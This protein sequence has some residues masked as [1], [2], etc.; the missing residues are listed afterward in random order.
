VVVVEAGR[1]SGS[2]NT[3]G[4]AT[5]LGRP[6]G[7]VPGPVTSPLSV[8][9]HALLRSGLA[10]CVTGVPDVVELVGG[11]DDLV[12]QAWQAEQ[13]VDVGRVQDALSTR[14]ERSTDE[15]AAASGL[16]LTTVRTLLAEMEADEL[17]ERRP[18]GWR[19]RPVP[20]RGYPDDVRATS[21]GPGAREATPVVRDGRRRP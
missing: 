11:Q 6:V 3:A 9:C 10:T 1:R 20:P 2:L 4:H 8:G 17:V 14:V 19:R 15:V 18:A 12:E 5:A 7:A 16:S 13:P 21:G